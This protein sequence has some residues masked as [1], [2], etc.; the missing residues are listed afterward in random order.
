MGL[1]DSLLGKKEDF[2]GPF[3]IKTTINPYRLKANSNDSA[4]LHI[5]IKN[6]GDKK[7]KV[8]VKVATPRDL[9]LDATT[10]KKSKVKKLGKMEPFEEKEVI[11]P[12]YSNSGTKPGE[13]KIGMVV[14]S[15][16]HDYEH[17][18]NAIKKITPIRV[19]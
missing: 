5:F 10:I 9:G 4:D 19:V 7:E 11:F 18:L 14:Y 6:N 13:Y 16:Y 1:L 15:H 2:K 8:S 12:V 3:K 17:I